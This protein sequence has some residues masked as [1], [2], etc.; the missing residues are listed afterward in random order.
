MAKSKGIKDMTYE[1]AFQELEGVVEKLEDG[2]LPL[3]QSLALFERG[4][5]LS[6]HCGSLLEKAEIK[7]R[8]LTEEIA[9]EIRE[10]DMDLEDN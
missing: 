10:I 2:T 6:K 5:E 8:K 7:L 4:Q 1:E 9:G 3:D